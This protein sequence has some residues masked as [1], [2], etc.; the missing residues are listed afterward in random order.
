MTQSQ[1]VLCGVQVTL[2]ATVM[3]KLPNGPLG[4]NNW[5]EH[6]PH[7]FSYAIM[8]CQIVAILQSRWVI[9]DFKILKTTINEKYTASK[10]LPI[11]HSHTKGS[12]QY[13]SLQ[14]YSEL[15][16]IL[17]SG[18]K[19]NSGVAGGPSEALSGI[20]R[21]AQPIWSPL[22]SNQFHIHS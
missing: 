4:K 11:T 2:A 7:F 1:L 12:E 8:L 5:W 18:I 9:H 6:G 19:N 22:S 15:Y 21:P 16:C 3:A 17:Y 14:I 10:Q 20:A 13:P